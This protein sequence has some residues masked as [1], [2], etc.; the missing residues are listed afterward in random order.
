MAEAK[1]LVYFSYRL[2]YLK[3]ED[4]AELRGGYDKLGKSLW[5]FYETV[6]GKG[7]A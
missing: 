4:Y 6:S 5:K 2:G 7:R 1:Y 3:G